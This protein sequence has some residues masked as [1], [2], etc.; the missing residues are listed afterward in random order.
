MKYLI[1]KNDERIGVKIPKE[2]KRDIAKAAKKMKTN[3]S[4]FIKMAIA[5]KL[6]KM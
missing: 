1:L 5:E 4:I 3:E 2:M 6:E